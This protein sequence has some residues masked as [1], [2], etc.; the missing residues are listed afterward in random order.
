MRTE[1]TRAA[2]TYL[3]LGCALDGL[4]E[5]ARHDCKL[6]RDGRAAYG[7]EASGET[8]MLEVQM[9]MR[10]ELESRSKVGDM[11]LIR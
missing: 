6:D 7:L 5:R 10:R 1:T 2:C 3:D 9:P 4:L 8:L 11:E